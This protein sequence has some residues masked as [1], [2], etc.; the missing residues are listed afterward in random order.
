MSVYA[1]LK[2]AEQYELVAGMLIDSAT[3]WASPDFPNMN[4]PDTAAAL[5][6]SARALRDLAKQL[7]TE[8]RTFIRIVN[9]ADEETAKHEAMRFMLDFKGACAGRVP[10]VNETLRA[11][12]AARVG[13]EKIVRATRLSVFDLDEP[14]E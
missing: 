2:L 13:P 9:R 3:L 10:G 14:A 1:D 11:A 7:K 5:N 12:A 6:A 4:A 8:P